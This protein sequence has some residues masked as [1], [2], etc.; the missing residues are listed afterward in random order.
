MENSAMRKFIFLSIIISIF[1][2]LLAQSAW[3][4]HSAAVY[5]P[6]PGVQS[7]PPNAR[8]GVSAAGRPAVMLN[9]SRDHQL[10]YKA[11]NDYSSY[12]NSPSQGPDMGYIHNQSKPY[13]GYFDSSK[14]YTYNQTLHYFQPDSNANGSYSC[15][16]KWHGNFLNWA[17][18]TRIDILRKVLYGGHRDIDSNGS[19]VLIRANLPM[20]SHSFV[21][22]YKSGSG[23]TKPGLNDIT[24]YPNSDNEISICN[25]TFADNNAWSHS[26]NQPP[27]M[28]VIKGKQFLWAAQTRKQCRYSSENIW[29]VSGS[30]EYPNITITNSY[31]RNYPGKQSSPYGDFQVKVEVCNSS[32]IGQERCKK[33][34]HGNYKPIGLL[35]EFGETDQMEFG[36]MTGSFSNNLR[37]GVLRKNVSSF[38]DEVDLTTGIFKNVNKIVSTISKIRINRFKYSDSLYRNNNNSVCDISTVRLN[39]SLDNGE[40][41]PWG[42]P[43]GEIFIESLRYFKGLPALD[44]FGNNKD[45]IGN[46]DLGLPHNIQWEDPFKRGASI[47]NI[48]GEPKCR[49]INIISFN[50]GVISYDSSYNN[51]DSS[52]AFSS[53]ANVNLNSEINKIGQGES[54]HGNKWFVGKWSSTSSLRS[55]A[56]CNA[57]T[58]NNL[59]EVSGICP[60]GAG[61]RGSF[62]IAGAAYWA[63]INA[64]RTDLTSTGN[65]GD[66]NFKVNTYAVSLAPDVP[67]IELT[68]AGNKKVI[69][70]PSYIL[71]TSLNEHGSGTFLDLRILSHDPNVGGEYLIFWEDSIA[72]ADHDMDLACR[73]SWAFKDGKK[74]IEISNQLFGVS[75]G[76]YHGCG[77]AI[78]GASGDG[79][80]ND[81]IHFVSGISGFESPSPFISNTYC[82]SGKSCSDNDQGWP[83]KTIT[84]TI[85][86]NIGGILKDPLYY[87]AKWGGFIASSASDTPNTPDKFDTNNDGIPDNFFSIFN[88]S[89]LEDSLRRQLQVTVSPGS[90]SF[91]STA[92]SSSVL[93]VGA[94]KYVAEFNPNSP[95][96]GNVNAYQVIA[97]GD[98]E[99]TPSWSGG[100]KLAAVAFGNRLVITNLNQ[101]GSL[102][103]WSGLPDNYK[104][105][106]TTGATN[107]MTSTKAQELVNYMR[108]DRQREQGGSSSSGYDWRARPTDNIM[109]PVV[110]ASPW[111]QNRPSAAY[112]DNYFPDYASFINTHQSRPSVLWVASNDGMVHGLNASTG[113]PMISYAPGALAP[114]FNEQIL[115]NKGVQSFVDGAPFTGDVKTTAN[116][117]KT[118]LFGTLGR[119]GRGIYALDVTSPSSLTATNAAHIFKWQFTADDD[120]DLGYILS[121]HG[122]KRSSR[123]ATPI[124]KLNNGKFAVIFGNGYDSGNKKA[125]LFILPVDGPNNLGSWS[126]R[127]YKI[128]PSGTE[129]SSDNGLS[130]P[131]WVDIDNNGTADFVYAGDLKGNVWKFDIRSS[132]PSAWSVSF[133]GKPLYS[134]KDETK[135]NANLP[136][137][138]MPEIIA[139]SFG[140]LMVVFGTGASFKDDQF[141][142]TNK[143]HRIFGIWDRP[144]F[145]QNPPG[146]DLPSGVNTLK[147]RDYS[148]GSSGAIVIS[149]TSSDSIDYFN[150]NSNQAQDGWYVN[151]R[152]SEMVVFNSQ[153]ILSGLFMS[154]IRPP[155]NFTSTTSCAAPL[156]A[157]TLF[158]LDP[159]SGLPS[160]NVF[161]VQ[162]SHKVVGIPIADQKVSFALDRTGRS[163][164]YGGTLK[165]ESGRSVVFRAIGKD[166]DI[167]INMPS[168]ESRLQWREVP[169]LRTFV[170]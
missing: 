48:F 132:V 4:Q 90:S 20:D 164:T 133:S 140:G 55:D 119:G 149:N 150:P 101:T 92:V 94:K 99:T 134:A 93:D 29:D 110:N 73:L 18:M 1:T 44:Y 80:I 129:N 104:T 98:F 123:Q 53:L 146:R 34:P 78:S 151:L 130:T 24:P 144:A 116:T 8:S 158:F 127:Y 105:M 61:S 145:S 148:E 64:I 136:I 46:Q 118:Y 43:I 26:T 59:E 68:G 62:S 157:S 107:P 36:L 72:G 14:C 6:M 167:G 16:G 169:G 58:V 60:I 69:I 121:D 128:I 86:G 21:K 39:S 47:D 85:T 168:T 125:G 89:G 50:S 143:T 27:L 112:F 56:F 109:G 131:N 71:D 65:F 106:L 49:Q 155:S 141:P 19:T 170:N 115:S 10:F 23:G 96:S 22:Y 91:S 45:D 25:T 32:K 54:I 12:V 40:C 137:V 163:P 159:L 138:S 142:E 102:F 87:A 66:P 33:Y 122:I 13:I 75:T 161:G 35:Q 31:G 41:S 162:G 77:Y 51:D 2:P 42:N 97:G 63:H 67:R 120:A 11:Y 7:I 165:S 15:S 9:I 166:T 153:R 38:K 156:P 74:K 30:S 5:T 154:T 126:G 83:T 76:D 135:G 79:I 70:Q 147:K 152:S 28:R 139:P 100:A 160:V 113:A 17:T 117:W 52:S 103:T 124:V 37:G 57:K 81:G 108:G 3:A 84:Y 111:V 95:I 114:R 82:K 88:P